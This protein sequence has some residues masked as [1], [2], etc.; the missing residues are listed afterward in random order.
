MEMAAYG[1]PLA[2]AE[3]FITFCWNAQRTGRGQLVFLSAIICSFA[4]R[5]VY[6]FLP[7]SG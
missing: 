1:H 2:M 6:S 7:G 5:N 3:Q 4:E